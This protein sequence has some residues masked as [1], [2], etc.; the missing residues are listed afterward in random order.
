M[1][2][3]Q[4]VEFCNAHYRQ[5]TLNRAKLALSLTGGN[6]RMPVLLNNPAHWHLRAREARQLASHLEDQEAK[7]ATLKIAEEYERLAVRATQR[8]EQQDAPATI[9][10]V[11]VGGNGSGNPERCNDAAGQAKGSRRTK[12]ARIADGSGNGPFDS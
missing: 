11:P 1:L 3:Q 2:N 6:A 7:A 4:F 12:R 10:G 8:L 5:H 9:G